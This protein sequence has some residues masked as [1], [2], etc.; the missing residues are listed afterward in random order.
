MAS[1]YQCAV[2]DISAQVIADNDEYYDELARGLAERMVE[3]SLKSA[4]YLYMEADTAE[5]LAKF[6]ASIKA[7][8]PQF[9]VCEFQRPRMTGRRQ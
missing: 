5:A 4:A 3:R 2:S 7:N 6:D 8:Y 9:I 1:Y